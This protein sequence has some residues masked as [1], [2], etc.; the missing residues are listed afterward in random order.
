MTVEL[1]VVGSINVDFAAHVGRLPRPGETVAASTLLRSPGGKGANQAV[2]AAR[3][4]RLGLV[5]ADAEQDVL[6][7]PDSGVAD[8][9]ECPGYLHGR[10]L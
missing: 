3:L 4:V 10:R 7:I 9:F 1:T 5:L 6:R 2:A 8:L